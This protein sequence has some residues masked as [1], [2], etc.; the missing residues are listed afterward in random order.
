MSIEITED[1]LLAAL[2]ELFN[3]SESA[4]ISLKEKSD[5]YEAKESRKVM[6]RLSCYGTAEGNWRITITNINSTLQAIHRMV[7]EFESIYGRKNEF[8]L[9]QEK[10]GEK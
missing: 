9:D 3:D 8:H 2:I 7:K 1:F 6:F 4:S 10:S 5:H